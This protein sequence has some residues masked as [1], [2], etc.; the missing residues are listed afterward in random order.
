[1][2][3]T[4]IKGRDF[5]S[6]KGMKK[7]FALSLFIIAVFIAF[8]TVL[9]TSIP[10]VAVSDLGLASRLPLF[11]WLGLGVVLVLMYLCR[12]SS[13]LLGVVFLLIVT[14]LFVVPV[15]IQENATLLGTSYPAAEGAQIAITGKLPEDLYTINK[16]HN[17]PGFLYFNAILTLITGLPLVLVCKFFPPLF[18]VF[19]GVI[20]Y[21]ILR[22]KLDSSKSILGAIWFLASWWWVAGNYFSPQEVSFAYF[23]LIFL[24][25]TKLVFTEKGVSRPLLVIVFLFSLAIV[26]THPFTSVVLVCCFVP[27]L[28]FYQK[29]SRPY[30]ALFLIVLVLAYLLLF[31]LPFTK[32]ALESTL[33]QLPDLIGLQFARVGL[34]GSFSH[35][36]T[37]GFRY[38]T[39]FI[40]VS[41]FIVF[42]AMLLKKRIATEKFWLLS[43]VGMCLPILITAYGMSETIIRVFMFGLIPLSYLCMKVLSKK[44]LLLFALIC[45]LVVANI[46]S[47]YGGATVEGVASSEIAGASFYV[48]YVPK[49]APWFSMTTTIA[50]LMWFESPYSVNYPTSLY[51]ARPFSQDN[52]SS[53]ALSRQQFIVY[54]QRDAYQFL[55]Y[56][57]MIPLNTSYL[58]QFFDKICDNPF[59][60]IYTNS[61]FVHWG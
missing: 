59:I 17:F 42:M 6:E 43:A 28:L 12:Q 5:E 19:I 26:I 56:Q 44:P 30:L 45:I 55:Y 1:M 35:T 31:A 33:R 3:L 32:W 14:Y 60:E 13:K 51:V 21:S 36:V 47:H 4:F 58:Q 50:S 9:T 38:L 24:I 18:A 25:F 23:A 10:Y 48:N 2:K 16:Y 39:M 52:V 8:L 11:F 29:M 41:V 15:A 7:F 40:T 27:V 20:I 34:I 49:D 22:I 46:P 61:T 37:N 53:T 54:S 57:G